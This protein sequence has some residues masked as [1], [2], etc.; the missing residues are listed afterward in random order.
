MK[1]S[2]AAVLPIVV[3]LL[4]INQALFVVNDVSAN[5]AQGATSIAKPFD[6]ESN[7]QDEEYEKAIASMPDPIEPFNRIMFQLNDKLYFYFFKP[8]A[9]GYSF[10]IP[11]TARISVSNFFSNLA[12]PIRL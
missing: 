12:T 5:D 1:L 6:S 3:S 4:C 11:E 9:K 2:H 8:I 10:V 7:N